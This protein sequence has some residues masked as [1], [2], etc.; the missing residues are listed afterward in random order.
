[1]PGAAKNKET[2]SEV[3]GKLIKKLNT[4]TVGEQND[5]AIS[6]S[7]GCTIEEEDSTYESLY[8]QADMALYQVKK[9]GKNNFIFY[10]PDFGEDTPKSS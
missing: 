10:S 1:M 9:S 7:I 8:Q 3:F 2:M 4:F 6:C 5:V